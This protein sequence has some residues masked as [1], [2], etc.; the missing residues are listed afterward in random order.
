MLA[1]IGTG[2]CQPITGDYFTVIRPLDLP[3][4]STTLAGFPF[5]VELMTCASLPAPICGAGPDPQ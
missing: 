5:A 4:S 2:S 1:A 3:E